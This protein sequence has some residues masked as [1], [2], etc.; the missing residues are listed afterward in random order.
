MSFYIVCYLLVYHLFYFCPSQ[1]FLLDATAS[2]E[3]LIVFLENPL[4]Q[5]WQ[6]W[7]ISFILFSEKFHLFHVKLENEKNSSWWKCCFIFVRRIINH[8]RK[9]ASWFLELITLRSTYNVIFQRTPKLHEMKL[10]FIP[11]YTYFCMFYNC[12]F[13]KN[14]NETL[15]I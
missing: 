1:S 13:L 3:L 4:E 9:Y 10:H 2:F 12:I 6:Q 11:S 14:T 5:V 7:F 8:A 15:N